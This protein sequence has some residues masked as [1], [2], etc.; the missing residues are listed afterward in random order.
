MAA[1]FRGGSGGMAAALS[2]NCTSA[3]DPIQELF[4]ALRRNKAALRHAI[5]AN[6]YTNYL[7]VTDRQV[8]LD[9]FQCRTAT[10]S[11][12]PARTRAPQATV[13][14]PSG[15]PKS[16]APTTTATTGAV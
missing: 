8:G 11:A 15:S 3:P 4:A 13:D 6:K 2:L 5:R 10:V 1:L 14:Q 9:R 7:E 12:T 16:T